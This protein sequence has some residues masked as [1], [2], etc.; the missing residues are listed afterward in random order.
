MHVNSNVSKL[1]TESW[2]KIARNVAN[3]KIRCSGA[4]FL[5]TRPR[6]VYF[7]R[8]DSAG[9]FTQPALSTYTCWEWAVERH[10]SAMCEWRMHFSG[11][12]WVRR[13]NWRI[14]Q[15][16]IKNGRGWW[17]FDDR[18]ISAGRTLILTQSSISPIVN[19]SK[20]RVQP[21]FSEPQFLL[22]R[23]S[24]L[25]KELVAANMFRFLSDDNEQ[26]P[27][28]HRTLHRNT[29]PFSNDCDY[30]VLTSFHKS[31]CGC[32]QI[33][34]L[35]F[36]ICKYRHV[37]PTTI[38]TWMLDTLKTLINCMGRG[39]TLWDDEHSRND[40]CW[41]RHVFASG[42]A[43]SLYCINFECV[44]KSIREFVAC[45]LHESI[46]GLYGTAV[47]RTTVAA[48]QWII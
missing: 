19:C 9:E 28:L 48:M 24:L 25:I 13:N 10:L 43:K 46:S 1:K 32:Q 35:V 38:G 14:K 42:P 3:L 29:K 27:Y 31:R 21:A 44:H 12:S 7:E 16:R 26:L 2:F 33:R 4:P 20:R 37:Y 15:V 30:I 18:Y 41:E 11:L 6:R 17:K 45:K 39:F 34:A 47:P 36:R 8:F 5:P 23:M 40:G 22:R